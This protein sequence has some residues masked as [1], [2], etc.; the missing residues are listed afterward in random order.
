MIAKLISLR[1]WAKRVYG[2]EAPAQTT[3]R[4]WAR[5]AQ[6]EPIPQKHGREY[7]VEPDARY[8]A[9]AERNEAAPVRHKRS[10]PPQQSA[11]A[12]LSSM[13]HGRHEKTA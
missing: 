11:T 1:A 2:D 5:T 6:I 3:L 7:F 9:A 4:K 12:L 13:I 8:R 10:V